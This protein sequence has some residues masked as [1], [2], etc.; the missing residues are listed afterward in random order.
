MPPN[1]ISCSGGIAD[2][3]FL[4]GGASGMPW[5]NASSDEADTSNAE[6]F[7]DSSNSSPIRAAEGSNRADYGGG[8]LP[9]LSISPKHARETAAMDARCV[10]SLPLESPSFTHLCTGS[11]SE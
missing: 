10:G 5:T 1:P 3:Q 11:G 2:S 8:F 7:D 4:G 6:F 9:T